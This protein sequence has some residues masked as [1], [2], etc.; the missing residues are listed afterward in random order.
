MK[1]F[2]YCKA[3][4]LRR[5][6]LAAAGLT[7]ALVPLTA[8]ADGMI[9]SGA[10]NSWID[11]VNASQAAQPHWMTPLVTVTPRLEQE[12][13]W[14]FYD[15]K[16][17]TGSQGNGQRLLSNG[18]PGGPRVE[19]IPTYNTE[20]IVAAPPVISASGPRGTQTLLEI[21]RPSLRSTGSFPPTRKTA[22]TL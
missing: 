2:E 1:G 3:R 8:H 5:L 7:V 11:M 20:I 12:L 6:G 9:D 19:F 13:R 22:T 4:E 16:N 18:G 15:Q 10:V 17:G 14:D 21:G